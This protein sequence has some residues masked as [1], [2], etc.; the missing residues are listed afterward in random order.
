[1]IDEGYALKLMREGRPLIR[2]T[3]SRGCVRRSQGPLLVT[4][5]FVMAF[6]DPIDALNDA[7]ETLRRNTMRHLTPKAGERMH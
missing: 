1:M 3:A 5:S 6:P 4:T 7:V 2:S